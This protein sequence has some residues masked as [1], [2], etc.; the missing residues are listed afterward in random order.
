M[1]SL[2]VLKKLPSLTSGHDSCL[3]YL[4]FLSW[5]GTTFHDQLVKG[6]V[7]QALHAAV[8]FEINFIIPLQ[9]LESR[10]IIM[11]LFEKPSMNNIALHLFISGI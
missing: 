8:R 5:A 4:G 7:C 3:L 6:S 9:L 2:L 1:T 10:F 11:C